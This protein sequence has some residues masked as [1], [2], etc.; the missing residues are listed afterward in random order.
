MGHYDEYYEELVKEALQLAEG[1]KR[2][3][4]SIKFNAETS[5]FLDPLRKIKVVVDEMVETH[6]KKGQDVF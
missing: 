4:P 2:D 3:K 1:K 6:I 5:N